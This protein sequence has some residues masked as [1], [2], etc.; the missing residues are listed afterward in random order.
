MH[1]VYRLNA[2][3]LNGQFVEALRTLFKDKEIEIM[4]SE[5]DE[6]AYLLQTEA[7]RTHLLRAVQNINDQRSLVD[8]QLDTITNKSENSEDYV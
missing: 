6:T 1:T 7:N 8:V 3:E 4:V 5:V 2:N